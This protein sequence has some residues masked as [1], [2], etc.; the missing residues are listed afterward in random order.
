M[1]NVTYIA[2]QPGQYAG[3]PEQGDD[4]MPGLIFYVKN[5]A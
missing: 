3:A 2:Y 1:K 5:N 4:R